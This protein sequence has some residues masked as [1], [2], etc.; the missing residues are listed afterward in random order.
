M[1]DLPY[2]TSTYNNAIDRTFDISTSDLL[3]MQEVLL[4]AM[5]WVGPSGIVMPDARKRR[6]KELVDEIDRVVVMW[7]AAGDIGSM[8]GAA[9]VLVRK[10][11]G[12]AVHNAVVYSDKKTGTKDK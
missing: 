12:S 3:L 7:A 9:D 2:D 5:Q 10:P 1:P 4:W 6:L 11:A 8:A